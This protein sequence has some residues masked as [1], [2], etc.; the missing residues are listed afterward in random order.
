MNRFKFIILGV[1]LVIA[2][3]LPQKQAVTI[4]D[5]YSFATPQTF[6]AAAI[7]MTVENTTEADDR[8]I[9]FTAD[10]VSGRTELHTMQMSNNI[11]RMR[12]VNEFNIDSNGGIITLEPMSD[13]VM[14]FDLKKD[15]TAG[16]TFEGVALFENA[17]EIPVTIQVKDREEMKN[18]MQ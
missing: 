12:R 2:G 1:P 15:L 5:A 18:F 7:F 9:E 3:C 16:E 14:L 10:E 8:M 17:G 13:H 6:P 11:M 4:T